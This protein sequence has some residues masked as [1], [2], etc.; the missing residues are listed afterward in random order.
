MLALATVSLLGMSIGPI[1]PGNFDG[2]LKVAAAVTA[3]GAI[4][5]K[6]AD[7]D[8]T[9]LTKF[10]SGGVW[11]TNLVISLATGAASSVVYAV[12]AAP[13][14]TA[15]LTACMWCASPLLSHS[16]PSHLLSPRAPPP[17][18]RTS[19]T[20][21]ARFLAHRPSSPHSTPHPTHVPSPT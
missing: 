16:V 15:K 13:F 7:I 19:A 6:Y 10:F 3:A 1:N 20:P 18:A 21:R 2:G 8:E 4:A 12:G 9:P 11:N 14:D 17:L 5:G